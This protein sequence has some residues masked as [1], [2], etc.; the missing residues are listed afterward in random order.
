[1]VFDIYPRGLRFIHFPNLLYYRELA[2]CLM[3]TMHTIYRARFELL[4][5]TWL[6]VI[7][8]I[9]RPV[10]IRVGRHLNFVAFRSHLLSVKVLSC[11]G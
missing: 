10:L 5:F 2:Y 1:M 4:H 9:R 7:V 8:P 3:V 6:R 11:W